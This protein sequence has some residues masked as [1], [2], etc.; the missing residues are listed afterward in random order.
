MVWIKLDDRFPEHPKVAGL[1][2]KA[3]RL[4]IEAM[5]YAGRNL[6]DGKLPGR[7]FRRSKKAT[8]EL[9]DAGLW[10]L[11][12]DGLE[13]H[14]FT[15][16]NP[17]KQKIEEK[18]EATR[19]R[20]EAFRKKRKRDQARLKELE[21]QVGNGGGNGVTAREQTGVGTNL[22]EPEPEPEPHKGLRVRGGG[23]PSG[24]PPLDGAAPPHEL[25]REHDD[26][27]V[28]K[29]AKDLRAWRGKE[30]E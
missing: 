22:P 19:Q 3:F 9:L 1:S 29:A 24:P 21:E 2:D 15:V 18:R 4:H 23:D 11:G 26:G 14:D 7:P 6:T 30:G 12:D 25:K 8:N 16:Y 10:F 17:P 27:E 28:A 20:V 13:I 5:C